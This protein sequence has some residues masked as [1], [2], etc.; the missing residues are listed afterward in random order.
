M[1]AFTIYYDN[2]RGVKSKLNSIQDYAKELEPTIICLV[3]THLATKEKIEIEGYTIIH[4]NRDADG[5]G[6]VFA[7]RDELGKI[8]LDITRKSEI[9]EMLWIRISNERIK[10]RVGIVYAPQESRTLKSKLEVMYRDIKKQVQTSIDGKEHLLLLGDFNCKI[11]KH[12][13]ANPSCEISKGGRLLLDMLK[14]KELYIVNESP[15]TVGTVT[16]CQDTDKSI[17]DYMIIRDADIDGIVSMKIDE[18]RI[19]TPFY[20]NQSKQGIKATFT[21]HNAIILQMNWHGLNVQKETQRTWQLTTKNKEKFRMATNGQTLSQIW[22]GQLSFQE[23][24]DLWNKQVMTTARKIFEK[25]KKSRKT[26]DNPKIRFRKKVRRNLN[27]IN[28]QTID[29]RKSHLISTQK[30]LLN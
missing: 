4:H 26:K 29:K 3:E 24:Y 20:L 19:W 2:L 10:I 17:L 25:D 12:I 30:K 23:K 11:G 8:C 6:I 14:E 21:D 15:K 9:G 16:R 22:K 5:G 27:R 1:K 18:E 13:K 7:I 28:I